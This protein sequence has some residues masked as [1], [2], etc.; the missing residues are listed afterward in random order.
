MS[1]VETIININEVA[2]FQGLEQDQVD[3]IGELLYRKSYRAGK[4]IITEGQPGEV[5]YII[6][7]GTVKVFA[8][9]LD[10]SEVIIAILG[11]GDTV[12]EMSMMDS[13]G[14]NASAVVMEPSDI[15]WMSRNDFQRIIDM[16]PMISQNLVRILIDRLRLSTEQIQSF[17]SLDVNGRVARQILAFARKYG[18]ADENGDTLIPI[19]LPQNE[20]A[21]LVGASRKRVN[22]TMVHFKKQ[23]LI[24]VAPNHHITVLNKTRLQELCQ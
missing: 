8:T 23:D 4:M 19:R 16:Y 11:A 5:I 3:R 22:Q 24:S 12:G 9:Q 2:L 6:L 21:E 20:I 7:S 17:A 18:E 10:G 1:V 15:M 13:A 14:R